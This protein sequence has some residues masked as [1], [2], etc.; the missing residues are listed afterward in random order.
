MSR[1]LKFDIPGRDFRIYFDEY[2]APPSL[3]RWAELFA[4]DVPVVRDLVIDIGFG[5]GEFLMD[6]A[7]NRPEQAYLGIECSH[8]R[9]HKMARRVA[10]T[11]IQNLRIVEGFAEEVLPELFASES[12]AEFWINFPDPWPKRN[13]ARRRI[14]RPDVVA[15]L[16]DQ[17]VPGGWLHVAT[18]D[19]PYAEQMDAV[20]CAEAGLEN[21]NAPDAWLPEVPGRE[22]TAYELEWRAQGRPLHFFAY[23]RRQ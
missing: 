1:T 22:P 14:V 6:L 12:I 3:A 23:R 17:L 15:L 5:R 13:H 2:A 20:L 21:C 8:K 10:K 11:E 19:P 4:D 18:D 16:A 9:V 7:A